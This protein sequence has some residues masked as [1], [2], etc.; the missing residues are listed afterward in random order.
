MQLV[1]V[2]GVSLAVRIGYL[3]IKPASVVSLDVGMWQEA[4]RTILDGGNPYLLS[5]Q[6]FLPLWPATVGVLAWL[7]K[8]IAI[9]FTELLWIVLIAFE[10][11]I[12]VVSF[13]ILRR[14]LTPKTTRNVLLIAIALNPAAIF[15]VTQHGNIDVI[16][17]LWV[18]L[19]VS[20]MIRFHE[21]GD[22]GDWLRACMWIGLGILTKTAPIALAPLLA[23]GAN[24]LPRSTLLRGAILCLLPAIMGFGLIYPFAPEQVWRNV[25]QYRSVHGYF[26]I[27]GLLMMLDGLEF[28]AMGPL[29]RLQAML[30]NVCLPAAML[31]IAIALWKRGWSDARQIPLAAAMVLL[32]ILIFGI[33]FGSQH[34]YWLIPPLAVAWG[35][36]DDLRWR[37]LLIAG[38][39]VVAGT[40]CF[41]YLMFHSHGG[42]LRILA[43]Q[44]EWLYRASL[45]F[46]TPADETFLQLPMFC[47]FVAV[48]IEGTRQFRLMR[49]AHSSREGPSLRPSASGTSPPPLP[50]ASGR[51]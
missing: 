28:P 9:P 43:P 39:V 11:A 8:S 33:G 23:A 42:L 20:A 15:Q 47:V 4:G 1:V 34:I 40:Y 27:S 7:S 14:W 36:I 25:V 38:W 6:N 16:F 29:V 13:G 12:I 32:S 10:T 50:G 19:A 41:K 17:M 45:V 37:R 48:L 31:T 26:G 21:H 30:F 18:M 5:H 24:R 35:M 51:A 46:V 2:V 44:S 22:P 49:R 3:L